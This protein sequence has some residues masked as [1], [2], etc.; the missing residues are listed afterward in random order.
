MRPGVLNRQ[1]GGRADRYR[2]DDP[3]PLL[4]TLY[5]HDDHPLEPTLRP[6]TIPRLPGGI[7]CH[8]GGEAQVCR[9]GSLGLSSR[10][11][12]RLLA[13]GLISPSSVSIRARIVQRNQLERLRSMARIVQRRAAP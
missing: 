7:R 3:N 12:L 11:R 4:G 2:I 13:A 5:L 1:P 10:A 9:S 8:A 6:H